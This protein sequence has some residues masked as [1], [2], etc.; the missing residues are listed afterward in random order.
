MDSKRLARQCT[1][2]GLVTF[3]RF[4]RKLKHKKD[5]EMLGKILVG[6]CTLLTTDHEIHWENSAHIPDEHPGIL[7][8]ASSAPWTITDRD[9]ERILR[10]FKSVFPNWHSISIQNLVVKLTEEDIEIWKVLG[11]RVV[12]FGRV[13]FTRDGWQ[14]KFQDWL[15]RNARGKQAISDGG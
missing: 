15:S 11:G 14:D 1:A 13:E 2:E 6:D 12:S 5:P 10:K 3:R 4:P 8:I 9:I 7:I